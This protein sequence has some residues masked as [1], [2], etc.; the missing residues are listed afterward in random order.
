MLKIP[1]TGLVYDIPPLK[2]LSWSIL[3][4]LNGETGCALKLAIEKF[5]KVP[6]PPSPALIKGNAV[7]K[8]GEVYLKT[9]V[10]EVPDDYSGHEEYIKML[11]ANETTVAEEK[12]VLNRAF[13]L[14]PESEWFNKHLEGF[15]ASADVYRIEGEDYSKLI[16]TDWKTGRYRKG[17][18]E[19]VELYALFA[20]E[21]W[22]ASLQ[23]VETEIAYV[24]YVKNK[25]TGKETLNDKFV[26]KDKNGRP[27]KGYVFSRKKDHARLK[28]KWERRFDFALTLK[29]FAP[30]PNNPYCDW[31]HH[32]KSNGGSCP[33]DK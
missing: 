12:W 11:K 2:A 33:L 15:R 8:R 16:I 32:R 30:N 9:D 27:E 6:V 23:I 7:H 29:Q 5:E 19:Q 13:E 10:D 22:N 21:I 28:R 14:L 1:K 25:D 26:G 20:F 31:C 18:S 4:A 17:Y 3:Q 24:G